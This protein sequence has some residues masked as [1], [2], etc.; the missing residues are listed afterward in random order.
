MANAT[1]NPGEEDQLQQTIEM[2]EVIVQS[3]RGQSRL[4]RCWSVALNRIRAKATP[5]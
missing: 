3:E 1:L 5:H 2:L 4:D